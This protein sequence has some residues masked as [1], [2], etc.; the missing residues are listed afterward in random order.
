MEMSPW[1]KNPSSTMCLVLHL[2]K[3]IRL[4]VGWSDGEGLQIGN[5]KKRE[6]IV[7]TGQM[8]RIASSSEWTCMPSVWRSVCDAQFSDSEDTIGH[9]Q[10]STP[11]T[12]DCFLVNVNKSYLFLKAL[13]GWVTQSKCRM[14]LL[15]Q[16]ELEWLVKLK[17]IAISS[18]P[19]IPW[20]IL[21]K[22]IAWA[23]WPDMY[24]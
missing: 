1:W 6:L 23:M 16:I 19:K 17:S 2:K 5:K 4:F 9:S 8:W 10:Q 14:R 15:A 22:L 7:I 11:Q 24:F 21:R 18:V 3:E 20:H 13:E 12:N